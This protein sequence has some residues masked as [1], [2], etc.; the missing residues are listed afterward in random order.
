MEITHVSSNTYRVLLTSAVTSN[1]GVPKDV[2]VH[3]FIVTLRNAT[4]VC[5]K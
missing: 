4:C 1:N 5:Q 2:W 3:A